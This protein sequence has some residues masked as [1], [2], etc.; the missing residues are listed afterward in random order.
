MSENQVDPQAVVV[1][2]LKKLEPYFEE[3]EKRLSKIEEQLSDKKS[4]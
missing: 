1:E 3:L 4:K 2:I